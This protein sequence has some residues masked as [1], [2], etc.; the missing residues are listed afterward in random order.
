M[1]LLTLR[2]PYSTRIHRH[3]RLQVVGSSVPVSS[4]GAAGIISQAATPQINV[5]TSTSGTALGFSFGAASTPASAAPA[6]AVGVTATSGVGAS[7]GQGSTNEGAASNE[8]Q[9]SKQP[10]MTYRQLQESLNKF[11]K[12]IQEEE[13]SF[14]EQALKVNVWDR[15]L[16]SNGERIGHLN[17]AVEKI[18]TDHS[19]LENTLSCLKS[20]ETEFKNLLA[21]LESSLPPG[22]KYYVDPARA[23]IFNSADSVGQELIEISN[24]LKLVIEHINERNNS[25]SQ[26]SNSQL[27]QIMKIVNEHSDALLWVEKHVMYLEKD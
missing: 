5:S 1:S 26:N 23:E 22:N 11:M 27:V 6:S 21:S 19:R 20:Q 7:T 17:T 9:G 15:T 18:I 3:R 10:T 25:S 14:Y 13:N 2:F 24:D 4:S 16:V 12:D 8:N